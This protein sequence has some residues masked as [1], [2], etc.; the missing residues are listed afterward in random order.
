[1]NI[2]KRE[3]TLTNQG[4]ADS[5][6]VNFTFHYQKPK[7]R[8]SG[9][10]LDYSDGKKDPERKKFPGNSLENKKGGN[11]SHYSTGFFPFIFRNEARQY[12]IKRNLE[13]TFLITCT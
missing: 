6:R 4:V 13:P 2:R 8:E 9:K 10:F 5:F 1:M 12:S 3:K 7:H 11:P